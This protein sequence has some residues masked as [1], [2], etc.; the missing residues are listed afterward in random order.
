MECPK[1]SSFQDS[2]IAEPGRSAQYAFNSEGLRRGIK[3]MAT[4]LKNPLKGIVSCGSSHRHS[5]KAI[6]TVISDRHRYAG[7]KKDC[8]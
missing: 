4:V 6:V 8:C 3:T 1:R 5:P 2:L 7:D